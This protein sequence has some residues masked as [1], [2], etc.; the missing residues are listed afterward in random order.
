MSLRRSGYSNN[1]AVSKVL[2]TAEKNIWAA[3]E[4]AQVF[5]HTVLRGN[6]RETPLGQ[7]LSKRLPSGYG[8]CSGEAVDHRDKH[9]TSLDLIVYD[10]SRISPLAEDP[11]LMPAESLLAVIEVKSRLTK[12][13]LRTCFDAAKSIRRLR[14]YKGR[15]VAA[16]QGG[17][18][19]SEGEYRC[20]YTIFAYSSDLTETDWLSKEAAR[21]RAVAKEKECAVD[22]IDRVVVLDKGLIAPADNAG[23]L[24]PNSGPSVFHEWFLHLMNYL[25]RELRY[26]P[27]MDWQAYASRRAIGWQ[28][29]PSDAP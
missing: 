5:E 20:L 14:P 25:N 1:D 7:F 11:Y 21:I 9:S 22:V 16:R 2:K 19:L 29:I 24:S 15:F 8:I 23:K 18:H 3:W 27:P 28:S 10:Q 13:E 6:A 17:A 4:K 26:R 12:A